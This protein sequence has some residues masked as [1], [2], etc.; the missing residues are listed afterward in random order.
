[1]RITSPLI[2]LMVLPVFFLSLQAPLKAQTIYG[3]HPDHWIGTTSTDWN[4]AANWD[5]NLVPMAAYSTAIDTTGREISL[6]G[7]GQALELDMSNGAQLTIL[8]GGDL[9]LSALNYQSYYLNVNAG[10]RLELQDP[11]VLQNL[12]SSAYISG[13]LTLAQNA[14]IL[15]SIYLGANSQGGTIDGGSYM[16]LATGTAIYAYGTSS[17]QQGFTLAPPNPLEV[18]G[19]L[20]IGGAFTNDG[21]A[22]YIMQGGSLTLNNGLIN[23]GGT[24]NL[25]GNIYGAGSLSSIDSGTT[26]YL[27]GG[28]FL[29]IGQTS[30][31]L[32]LTSNDGTLSVGAAYTMNSDF[33][34]NGTL[35]ITGTLTTGE[36]FHNSDSGSVTV[37]GGILNLN[38]AFDGNITVNAGTLNSLGRIAIDQDQSITLQP[39]S[40]LGFA[41]TLATNN[42]TLELQAANLTLTQPFQNNGSVIASPYVI[43]YWFGDVV[44]SSASTMAAPGGFTNN[45]VLTVANNSSLDF[46]G[47]L[48]NAAG[49][50]I[51]NTQNGSLAI[52]GTFTNFGTLNSSWLTT[53][54][55]GNVASDGTLGGGTYNLTGGLTYTGSNITSI[56]N[57][58]S[59]TLT[60][61]NATFNNTAGS[62]LTFTLAQ[63]DGVFA[64]NGGATLHLQTVTNNG[65]MSF[66]DS[67]TQAYVYG[68]LRNS[69]TGSLTIQN[70]AL[71]EALFVQNDGTTLVTGAN[72]VFNTEASLTNN[73]SLT[74][75]NGGSLPNAYL[76][77][78]T[79]AIT[80]TDPG[81]TASLSG[82]N[83]GSVMVANGGQA[84]LA[85]FQNLS[86]ATLTATDAGTSLI[87]GDGVNNQVVS[88][89]GTMTVQNGA[90]ASAVSAW[91]DN[92]GTLTVTGAGSTL[93]APILTN[94]PGA[95]LSVLNGGAV[96]ILTSTAF[97]PG[98]SNNG[99]M[100]IDGAGSTLDLSNAHWLSLGT[101]TISHGG[102]VM[103]PTD[104]TQPT[105]LSNVNLTI[106]SGGQLVG[107][108]GSNVFA[109]PFVLQTS[110]VAFDTPFS[111]PLAAGYGNGAILVNG[112]SLT[113]PGF[114]NTGG[115]IRIDAT[116]SADFRGGAF[117][118]LDS[119]GTLNDGGTY[120]LSGPLHYDASSGLIVNNHADIYLTD[121]GQLLSGTQNALTSLSS[122]W[123]ALGMAGSQQYL[124]TSGTLDN[125]GWLRL[126]DNATVVTGGAVTNSGSVDLE[127]G[128]SLTSGGDFTNSGYVDLETGASLTVLGDYSN[129]AGQTDIQNGGSLYA[130]GVYT[131]QSTT[132]IGAQSSLS[133][134]EYV[135]SAPGAN[136]ILFG[137]IFAPFDLSGG[138][139][140]SDAEIHG[141]LTVSGGVFAPTGIFQIDGDYIQTG[142]TLEFDVSSLT[143]FSQLLI[144]GAATLDG[145]IE[146]VLLN[147]FTFAP[148]TDIALFEATNGVTFGSDLSFLLPAGMEL[149]RGANGFDVGEQGGQNPVPEPATFG[150]A[151]AA[152]L[153]IWLRRR[154]RGAVRV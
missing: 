120:D 87:L 40:S 100:L 10:G 56:A 102:V 85:Y 51:N 19:S 65:T 38:G 136:T 23:Y 148:N 128:G 37:S 24:F 122:N 63:N 33:T 81:S 138:T 99:N 84:T 146:I 112:S 47:N 13:E 91:L 143:D 86:G 129:L 14:T 4:S 83:Q 103:I 131:N 144:G 50:I 80:V 76:Q 125:Y 139:L 89:Y 134:S 95:N 152:L 126:I 48:V 7:S 101:T 2:R 26:M 45:G 114:D 16:Y 153:S 154:P 90:T 49:G 121:G 17:I 11:Y 73:G 106:Q 130:S 41:N 118:N 71:V 58:T 35:S 149:Y 6:A 141:N 54:V 79:G 115:Y 105:T 3:T 12:G 28:N 39:G 18:Y 124:S 8:R 59:V 119:T 77:N 78:G 30:G 97:N 82:Y 96:A 34:N 140:S 55:L 150:L 145:T 31:P 20:T 43:H 147:G 117:A 60:G 92:S 109:G 44:Q 137:D 74:V 151:A 108:G 132:Y 133:A 75:A 69:A 66:S 94:E 57:G 113:A 42:G 52:H 98:F 127:T 67:G 53:D 70:G 15:G 88:N 46:T 93:T 21:A 111:V 64:A 1:M 104:I 68:T 29:S 110:S 142:G 25:Q 5:T 22:L 116:S 32:T 107:T 62:P 36:G 9:Q 27:D 72:S 123:G 61:P 135:Q